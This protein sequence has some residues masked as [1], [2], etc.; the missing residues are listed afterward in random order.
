MA[1]HRAEA[2]ATA[3]FPFLSLPSEM[4]ERIYEILLGSLTI[5]VGEPGGN[6]LLS[7]YKGVFCCEAPISDEEA[8]A[9]SSST[10]PQLEVDTVEERH[11]PCVHV[12]GSVASLNILSVCKQTHKEATQI[13]YSTNIFTFAQ[14]KNLEISSKN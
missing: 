3:H 9:R 13:F 6:G 4:R 11:E 1:R 12:P 14:P 2:R 7:N 5:H 8:F 10:E